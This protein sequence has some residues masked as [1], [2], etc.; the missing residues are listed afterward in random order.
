MKKEIEEEL[1]SEGYAVVEENGKA[2]LHIT[3][4]LSDTLQN[5]KTLSNYMTEMVIK[6]SICKIIVH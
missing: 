2:Y 3:S 4:Q 1:K 6:K 5:N